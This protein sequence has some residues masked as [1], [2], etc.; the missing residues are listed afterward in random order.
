MRFL[1][2]L[3][4]LPLI[5]RKRFRYQYDEAACDSNRN[6]REFQI[7]KGKVIGRFVDDAWPAKS[8][9]LNP[10]DFFLSG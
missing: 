2:C 6:I 3:D 8:Q 4:N 1:K 7:F 9:C 10:L 5:E